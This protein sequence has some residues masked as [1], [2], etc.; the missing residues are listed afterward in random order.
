MSKSGRR[1]QGMALKAGMKE[2]S[3][4]A[5]SEEDSPQLQSLGGIGLITATSRECS[6]VPDKESGLVAERCLFWP[7]STVLSH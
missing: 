5:E 1:E 3:G 7:W 2:P 6:V 4:R